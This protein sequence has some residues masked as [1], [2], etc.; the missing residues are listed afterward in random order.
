MD[1]KNSRFGDI[2]TQIQLIAFTLLAPEFPLL[3][4]V[5][6]LNSALSTTKKLGARAKSDRVPWSTVHSFFANMGGFVI[7]FKHATPLLTP[8]VSVPGPKIQV[9]ALDSMTLNLTACKVDTCTANTA[10]SREKDTSSKINARP[11]LYCLRDARPTMT[12]YGTLEL[13]LD[14]TQIRNLLMTMRKLFL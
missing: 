10:T 12:K 7:H 6:G 4:A 3:K 9:S 5:A 11:Q 1:N 14:S 8:A 13:L 2:T